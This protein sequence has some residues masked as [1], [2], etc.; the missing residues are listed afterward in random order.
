LDPAI[1]VAAAQTWLLR[2][3]WRR[4]GLISPSEILC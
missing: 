3:G 1:P 2:V 4:H